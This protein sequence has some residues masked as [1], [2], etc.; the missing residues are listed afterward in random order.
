MEERQRKAQEKNVVQEAQDVL[1]CK[2]AEGEDR[3][4]C[5]GRE[6]ICDSTG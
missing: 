3:V 5:D 2:P 6:G 4:H 1:Q